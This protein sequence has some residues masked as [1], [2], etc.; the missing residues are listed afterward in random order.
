MMEKINLNEAL[1]TLS[2]IVENLND[3]I[4]AIEKQIKNESYYE[5]KYH[6]LQHAIDNLNNSIGYIIEEDN[7]SDEVVTKNYTLNLAKEYSNEILNE[8]N[9]FGVKVVWNNKFNNL[10][11][12]ETDKTKEG[13]ESHTLI[14]EAIENVE[15][16]VFI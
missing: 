16:S 10:I 4:Y 13:L 9:E 12:V 11:I 8:L 3:R 15:G 14:N 5:D 2:D 7:K 1:E 6:R